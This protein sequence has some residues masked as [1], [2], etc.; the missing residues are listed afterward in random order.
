MAIKLH[1]RCRVSYDRSYASRGPG[2]AAAARGAA[3]VR[4]TISGNGKSK[5]YFV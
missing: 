3:G 4:L 1:N 5:F 2:P